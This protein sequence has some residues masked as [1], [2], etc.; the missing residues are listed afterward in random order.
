MKFKIHKDIEKAKIKHYVPPKFLTTVPQFWPD[1]CTIMVFKCGRSDV[2]LSNIVE[3]ALSSEILVGQK[4]IIA[5]GGCFTIES[6]QLLKSRGISIVALS[7]FPW[8]DERYKE[9][10]GSK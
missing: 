6:E 2:I 10:K 4:M 5:F 9:I 8:T 7:N 1:K 3:D